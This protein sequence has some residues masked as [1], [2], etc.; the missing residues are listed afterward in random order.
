MYVAISLDK[1]NKCFCRTC[2]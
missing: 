2:K 1:H